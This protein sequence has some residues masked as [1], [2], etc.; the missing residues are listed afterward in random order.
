MGLKSFCT[1][2][3]ATN[4]TKRQG[5]GREK[6]FAHDVTDEGYESPKFTNSS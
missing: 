2:K 6:I 3:E 4:K 5:T 1:A